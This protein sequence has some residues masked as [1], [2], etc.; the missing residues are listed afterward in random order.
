M[1]RQR[2]SIF[3]AL[4]VSATASPPSLRRAH[5]YL[6]ALPN[7]SSEAV[8][9]A[10]WA[11]FGRP[12]TARGSHTL[13]LPAYALTPSGGLGLQ[14]G[15]D[16]L[17]SFGVPALRAQSPQPRVYG[18]LALTDDAAIALAAANTSALVAAL[19]A[20]AHALNYSGWELGYAPTH[21]GTGAPLSALLNAS[22]AALAARGLELSLSV[23]GCPLSGDFACGD[24]GALPLL[25][26]ATVDSRHVASVCAL[27]ALQ[28]LDGDPHTGVGALWAPTLSPGDSGQATFRASARFLASVEACYPCISVVAVVPTPDWPQPEW[29]F[30]SVNGFV[31]APLPALP[32][33]TMH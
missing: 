12:P 7:A 28:D 13:V 3:F 29:F 23:Q 16:A 11:Q 18:G 20:R 5:L 6:A 26:V 8:Y 33:Q 17:E 22:G 4:V 24:A 1:S 32:V 10:S 14:P 15:G 31:D 2:A 30:D 25:A 21:G 9:A 27:E 19:V